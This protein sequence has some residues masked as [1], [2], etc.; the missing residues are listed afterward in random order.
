VAKKYKLVFNH[1]PITI[2]L[3]ARLR[4][5]I[6][7]LPLKTCSNFD[8]TINATL[9]IISNRVPMP[10]ESNGVFIVNFPCPVKSYSYKLVKVLKV[11]EF[12]FAQNNSA[13][14]TDRA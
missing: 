6:K 9:P 4:E 11:L 13:L 1:T 2:H 10:T 8:N 12:Q 14:L 5:F 7:N 3:R